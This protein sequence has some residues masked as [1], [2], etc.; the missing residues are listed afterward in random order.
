MVDFGLVYP[1]ADVEIKIYI[2]SPR[3]INF[4]AN[5]SR[6]TRFLKSLKNIYG[7]NQAGCVWNKHFHCG[8]VQLRFKQAKHDSCIY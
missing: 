4:G 2:K 6:A 5:I 3:R 1:Q 8:L 7:L